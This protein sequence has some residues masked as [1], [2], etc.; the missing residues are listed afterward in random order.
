MSVFGIIGIIFGSLLLLVLIALFLPVGFR[1]CVGTGIKTEFYIKILCFAI[2]PLSKKKKE[3]AEKK[4]KPEKRSASKSKIRLSDYV[5][6]LFSSLSDVKDALAAVLAKAVFSRFR[7]HAVCAGDDAAKTAVEYGAVCA[8]L[9]PVLAFLEGI[10]NIR[11]S[12]KDVAVM[13]DF[14]QDESSFLL[15]A[16]VY[17]SGAKVIGALWKPFMKIVKEFSEVRNGQ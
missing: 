17:I 9:Y 2:E 5:K 15:D 11:E 7:L 8:V 10:T 13:C 3:K 12:G 1:F 16:T 6:G 4:P 14:L